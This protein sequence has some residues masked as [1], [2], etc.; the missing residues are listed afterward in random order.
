MTQT[1]LEKWHL[2]PQ[3]LTTIID[4]NPSLRGF[5][6]GYIAEYKLQALL[7]AN[8][9]V[10]NLE[11]PDDHARGS[12]KK[13]DMLFAYKGHRFSLEVKSLQTNSVKILDNHTYSGKAQVDASDNRQVT[14]P[15]GDTIS[16]TCLV[17]GEFDIL[18]IN[19]FQFR[20]QWD[21]GFILNR[22]LPRSTYRKY[23]PEQQK[24]LLATLVPVTWPL[25]APF[26]SN[27]FDLLDR[28]IAERSSPKS[29]PDSF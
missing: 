9:Q 28:L 25:Q 21:F 27:P 4:E 23:T 6:L 14:L 13:N 5:M 19:L 3:E 15:N 24:Y 2:T 18:A 7:S 8:H 17:V 10:S 26:K 22:D 11:K 12:G 29:S 16:T 1:I 20:E